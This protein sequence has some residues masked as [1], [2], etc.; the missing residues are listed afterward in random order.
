MPMVKQHQRSLLNQMEYETIT[1]TA[2]EIKA[3]EKQEI[4]AT[5]YEKDQLEAE[6]ELKKY[7]LGK[8]LKG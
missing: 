5:G 1:D 3:L 7:E 2:R 4:N 8:Y 6:I